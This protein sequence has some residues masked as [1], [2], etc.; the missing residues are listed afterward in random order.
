MTAPGTDRLQAVD[1]LIAVEGGDSPVRLRTVV[2][3]RAQ[4]S[5]RQLAGALRELG[6]DLDISAD[7]I[8]EERA[9]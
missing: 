7:R 2:L 3:D 5:V 6:D 4:N 9:S 8:D 1:V